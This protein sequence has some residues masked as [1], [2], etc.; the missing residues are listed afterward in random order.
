MNIEDLAKL[1]TKNTPGKKKGYDDIQL[2]E[3]SGDL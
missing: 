1:N 3:P 2:S